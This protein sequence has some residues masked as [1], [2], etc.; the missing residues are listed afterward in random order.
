MAVAGL[1]GVF[2]LKARVLL[3]HPFFLLFLSFLATR[4]GRACG[5]AG[6]G[7]IPGHA[8]CRA[9]L[10]EE[11]VEVWGTGLLALSV[12]LRGCL[13]GVTGDKYDSDVMVFFVFPGF[14]FC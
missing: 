2:L 4:Q 7:E 14:V 6:V 3:K 9:V 10:A 13:F 11:E 1:L 5:C 8:S 12:S